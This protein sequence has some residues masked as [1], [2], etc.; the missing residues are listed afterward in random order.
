MEL[1]KQSYQ[2]IVIL[3]FAFSA[4]SSFAWEKA[5]HA[6]GV[7]PA[8][9]FEVLRSSPCS[10]EKLPRTEEMVALG[11]VPGSWW[12]PPSATRPP[13]PVPTLEQPEVTPPQAPTYGDI[14]IFA[15]PGEYEPGS[16]AIWPAK[17]L[18][19]VTLEVSALRG[20]SD[21]TIPASAVD[22]RVV[23]WVYVA[24][25][26]HTGGDVINAKAGGWFY[27]P[28]LL[29][30][31]DK[32]VT[33]VHFGTKCD[34][35]YNVLKYALHDMHDS[36]VLLP[37]DLVAKEVKWF[38]LTVHVPEDAPPG[39]YEGTVTIRPAEAAALIVPLQV[40]VLPFRLSKSR[41]ARQMYYGGGHRTAPPPFTDYD[42]HDP[43][44]HGGHPPSI[45][46]N[47]AHGGDV[48]V[49]YAY[50]TDEQIK[51]DLRDMAAHGVDN[52][53]WYC[54]PE[55]AVRLMQDTGFGDGRTWFNVAGIRSTEEGWAA[56][57]RYLR[58]AGYDQIYIM[59]KDEPKM[60]DLDSVRQTCER[61]QKLGAKPW[62]ALSVIVPAS[63]HMLDLIDMPNL[64]TGAYSE[65]ESRR[66]VARWHEAGKRV[67]EYGH[68]P[69]AV[70]SDG[71]FRLH[72]GLNL[73][74]RGVDGIFDFAYQWNMGPNSWDLLEV[75]YLGWTLPVRKGE[76]VPFLG[77]EWHREGDDDLRYLSTLLDR[78]EARKRAKGDDAIASVVD[79]WLAELRERP[80]LVTEEQSIQDIRVRMVEH[81]V[82]L[83]E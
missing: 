54:P 29:V 75:R 67:M 38:W 35:G 32:L 73:W 7:S 44:A 48:F 68:F 28:R 30:R 3:I 12:G 16:L 4:A 60:A 2:T 53:G 70:R 34:I 14:R 18:R 80:T 69:W 6:S 39:I 64:F 27:F 41:W 62:T 25:A 15:A 83:S 33:S 11:L 22:P 51:A 63:E 58:A 31:D 78:L 19:G 36:P 56:A 23:K 46:M 77:W 42:P 55:R 17:D 66:E 61:L 65:E 49:H 9:G 10:W 47:A 57:I 76:P 50:K 8:G 20:D 74:R 13:W 24:Q 59:V 79:S 81:I 26:D 82:T 71:R 37:V 45:H 21:Y 72:Y 43:Q 52:V 5:L 1:I 40:Q